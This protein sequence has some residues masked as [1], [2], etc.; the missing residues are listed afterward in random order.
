LF[1]QSTVSQNSIV[2]D[3]DLAAVVVDIPIM[4][5][6]LDDDRVVIAAIAV[7]HDIAVAHRVDIAVAMALA[8]R[9]ADR[10]DADAD[11]F[12]TGWQRGSDHRGGRYNS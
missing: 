2:I 8:D 9:H 12:R 11:F 1:N 10:A 7:A 5:A 6:L 4:V 3:D